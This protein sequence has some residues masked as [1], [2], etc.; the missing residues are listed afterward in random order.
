[1]AAKLKS[2]YICSSCG[3]ESAKWNGRCP[4]CGEWNTFE[5]EV[6]EAAPKKAGAKK[7]PSALNGEDC[8]DKVRTLSQIDTE[9][10]IRY[11]TGAG[12]LDRVLG[13]GLVRW[14]FWAASR[15]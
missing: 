6:V 15:E 14:C 9:D 2:V 10:E 3:Y 4:S 8:S 13:G 12:E 7:A 5:E 1:M 11:S